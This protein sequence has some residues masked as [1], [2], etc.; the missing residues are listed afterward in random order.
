[1]SNNV[2]FKHRY[3]HYMLQSSGKFYVALI[4]LNFSCSSFSRSQILRVFFLFFF[5]AGTIVRDET[6]VNKEFK[7]S[8]HH[9][10]QHHHVP[11]GLGVFPVP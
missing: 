6:L 8:C 7:T 2:L 11:E 5:P 9:Y 4:I 10:H 1:M 3:V